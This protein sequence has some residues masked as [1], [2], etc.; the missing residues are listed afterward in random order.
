MEED[1]SNSACMSV[2]D[3]VR[4][5]RVP[6]GRVADF[7]WAVIRS[8]VPHRLLFAAHAVTCS[9]ATW[10]SIRQR[11]WGYHVVTSIE[12]A[13][14]RATMTDVT[15]QHPHSTHS[16][17]HLHPHPHSPTH[18]RP[19][20]HRHPLSRPH[21][22]SHPRSHPPPP[23]LSHRL[24]RPHSL[25]GGPRHLRRAVSR[26]ISLN[27]HD[28]FSLASAL[29]GLPVQTFPV[30]GRGCQP[31]SCVLQWQE[32]SCWVEWLLANLVVPAV[33][34]HFYATETEDGRHEV[35]FY[36]KPVWARIR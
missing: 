13:A 35:C 27:R 12:G 9:C 19:H 23:P 4:D 22:H 1:D 16:D 2:A 29:H 33:R 15:H 36:R 21:L 17:T 11:R 30:V 20:S 14:K 26:F 32:A 28:T 24:S 31:G 6:P 34:A 18:G 10:T 25:G 7:V 5:C 8:I 3:M